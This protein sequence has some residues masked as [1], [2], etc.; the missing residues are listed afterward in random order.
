[1]NPIIAILKEHNVSDEQTKTV[2]QALTENPMMAMV[3]VQQL[4][5]PQEKLQALMMMLIQDPGLIEEAVNELGF[6]F[7]KVEAAKASL[8]KENP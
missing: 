4:G 6:D 3:T 8:N 1:M 7:S 2:F 5:I